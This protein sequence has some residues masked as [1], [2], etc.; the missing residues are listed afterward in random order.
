MRDERR[1]IV[2][3]MYMLAVVTLLV[4]LVYMLEAVKLLIVCMCFIKCHSTWWIMQIENI[5]EQDCWCDPKHGNI[6]SVWF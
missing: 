3:H 2:E 5:K 1:W 6:I 4:L